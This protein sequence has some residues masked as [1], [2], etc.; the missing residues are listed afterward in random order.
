MVARV[1][2]PGP[3]NYVLT[4][5]FDKANEKP[6]FHMGIKTESFVGKNLD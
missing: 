2:V 4:G 3:G 1:K 5:D 6:K